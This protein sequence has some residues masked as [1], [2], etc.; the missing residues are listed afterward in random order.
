MKKKALMVVSIVIVL[1]L[2]MAACAS[3]PVVSSTGESTTEASAPSEAKET[4]D[5]TATTAS[6]KKDIKFYGKIVEYTSGEAT[7]EKLEELLS[8]Q[9]NIESLQVDWGNLEQVIRTG[10]ASGDPCDVYNYWP[11]YIS[12]FTKSDMALD[13]TPY[14]DADGGAW[15]DSFDEN[16]LTLGEI[17]GK[18][19]DIPTTPNFSCLIA[20]KELFEQAGV[21]VPDSTYWSWDDFLKACE[22][23]KE[24]DIFPMSAPTDNQKGNWVWGNGVLGYTKDA[25]KVDEVAQGKVACTDDIFKNAFTNTKE[26][27]DKEYMYPGEGAVTLTTDEGRAAFSQGK[28]ALCAE[29]AAGIGAVIDSLPFEAVIVPWPSMASET[30]ITGGAD[31]LFIPANVKD[32]DAAVKVLKTYTSVPVQQI[33]A[34]NG[35]VVAVKG[36]TSDDPTVKKLSDFT[37]AVVAKEIKNLDPVMSD[38]CVNQALPEL[39]LGGG[40]DS[41]MQAMEDI[42]QQIVG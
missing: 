6:A 2:L 40:V 26:L 15:R 19:Y 7:C 42:R 3:A 11:Q 9:Y 36:T 18:V 13:L 27:Y 14:L 41:V 31:G 12:T 16:L 39:I 38:Y 32:P 21:P 35:F 34:D 8:D 25:N 23:F 4:Q 5:A 17:D 37:F 24:K 28:T 29:V 20:N 22:T 1:C 33:N 10:I 30:A